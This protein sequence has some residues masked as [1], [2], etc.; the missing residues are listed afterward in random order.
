[1][2][3]SV[4]EADGGKI[5]ENKLPNGEIDKKKSEFGRLR[6]CFLGGNGAVGKVVEGT[7]KLSIYNLLPSIEISTMEVDLRKYREKWV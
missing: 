3:S 4:I 1:M 6:R 7:G 5:R 2:L